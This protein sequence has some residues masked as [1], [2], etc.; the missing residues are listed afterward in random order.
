M[1]LSD[2]VL[3]PQAILPL[4]IFEPRYRAM[5][6][7]VLN[8]DR[9]FAIAA[10]DEGA[11]AERELETPHAV[12]GIGIVRAC[13]KNPDGTSNL[14]LQGL[15][16]VCLDDIV[17]EKPFRRARVRQ[18]LTSPGGSEEALSAIKPKLLDLIRTQIRLGARIPNEVLEFL[19]NVE[20]PEIFLDLAISTLCHEGRLK[21]RLLET[22]EVIA[23][24]RRFIGFLR[25]EIERLKLERKL[26]GELDDDAFGNN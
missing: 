19:A 16:R 7:E 2:T 8:G 1:T 25:S 17:S 5:L 24:Y 11:P 21:Q 4:Y 12:A 15:A 13:Q 26:Q 23:R 10:L 22:T 14:L 18:V 20:V 3:F 6:E 9:I